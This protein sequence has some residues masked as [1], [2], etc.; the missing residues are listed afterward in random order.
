MFKIKSFILLLVVFVFTGCASNPALVK[1]ENDLGISSL[2][3]I[4]GRELLP[5]GHFESP[6]LVAV[7]DFICPTCTDAAGQVNDWIIPE[8]KDYPV[9]VVGIARGH[10]KKDTRLW[11]D[12][13]NIDFDLVADPDKSLSEK[14]GSSDIPLFIFVTKSGKVLFQ[15]QGW[16][17]AIGRTL[18]NDIHYL[19]DHDYSVDKNVLLDEVF[20][21]SKI[22]AAIDQFPKAIASGIESR[23]D[24]I[25][26]ELYS[27][28]IDN[29]NNR[30][31]VEQMKKTIKGVMAS[32]L[33]YTA[34]EDI[35]KWS[36]ST[37]GKKLLMIEDQSA[38]L[39]FIKQVEKYAKSIDKHRPPQHRVELMLKIDQLT[40]SSEMLTDLDMSSSI[41]LLTIL[42]S[43]KPKSEQIGSDRIRAYVFSR[44]KQI[45][46]GN[47]GSILMMN[48][49]MYR[50][51]SDAE[52]NQYIDWLESSS[53]RQFSDL[54]AAAFKSV[55]LDYNINI[56]KG[57]V[58]IIEKYRGMQGV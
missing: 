48:L 57:L 20:E 4:D 34:L 13:L 6:T 53:G 44:Q 47:R 12:D 58:P 40:S 1:R 11:R 21:V 51:V 7:L 41:D 39:D 50:N 36:K 19:D 8:L 24:Y 14:F 17:S 10:E 30:L 15:Y 26:A 29:V 35:K 23:K 25:P 16:S 43:L 31:D 32:H 9:H 2:T 49:Y 45:E 27:D 3:T 38:G 22:S 56:I 37:L 55:L 54:L 42:D 28:L 46:N 5:N 52:M 18:L 33:D